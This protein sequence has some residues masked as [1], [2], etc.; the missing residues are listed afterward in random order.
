MDE[1]G[2][3]GPRVILV[4]HIIRP[5]WNG[6]GRIRGYCWN[7]AEEARQRISTMHPED[8][9]SVA[10]RPYDQIKQIWLDTGE[11]AWPLRPARAEPALPLFQEIDDG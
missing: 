5:G 1:Q 11:D 8:E 7:G 6:P 2:D 10:V 3:P 4:E 9:D